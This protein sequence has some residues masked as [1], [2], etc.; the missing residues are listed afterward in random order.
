MS[1]QEF[2][3]QPVAIWSDRE[4]VFGERP[5]VANGLLYLPGT[6]VLGEPGRAVLFAHRW[7]GYHYDPLPRALG[8]VLADRGVAMLSFGLRRRGLEGPL[9][10][11]PDDDVSDLK[12][13]LDYL[14]SVGYRDV[15]LAGEEVG[16]LSVA[17]YVRA[18]PRPAGCGCCAD[19]PG[20]R[21]PPPDGGLAGLRGLRGNGGRRRAR[22]SPGC[23]VRPSDRW[24][25]RRRRWAV[26]P[27]VPERRPCGWR[28]GAPT[29]DTKLSRVVERVLPPLLI[30]D[31]DDEWARTLAERTASRHV[32]V[33]PATDDEQAAAAV[34]EWADKVLADSRG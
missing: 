7:G 1:D 18:T 30:A 16:A 28:G 31:A 2:R 14:A 9:G 4:Q 24:D 23:G 19:P 33:A 11:A 21:P 29:A 3:V 26:D 13:A 27:G 25:L 20:A 6:H 12:L 5:G 10:A 17:R 32:T 22:L 15:A 8:P 34:T